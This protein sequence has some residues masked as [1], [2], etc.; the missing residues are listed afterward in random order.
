MHRQVFSQNL[1][2]LFRAQE[3]SQTETESLRVASRVDA[4]LLFGRTGRDG[5]DAVLTSSK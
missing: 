2:H 4:V 1:R 5:T 3:L